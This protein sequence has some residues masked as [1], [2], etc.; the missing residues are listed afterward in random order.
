MCT[1]QT[2]YSE[3]ERG[4]RSYRHG[5]LHPSR[6]F[7][8]GPELS[9]FSARVAAMHLIYDCNWT[10]SRPSDL[11]LSSLVAYHMLDETIVPASLLQELQIMNRDDEADVKKTPRIIGLLDGATAYKKEDDM[12]QSLHC[13]PLGSTIGG[14]GL[15]PVP[16]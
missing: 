14:T 3:L 4:L 6:E 8:Y 15:L 13:L 9:E 16:V 1:Q 10:N 11:T 12:N 2:L 5:Q 7:Q